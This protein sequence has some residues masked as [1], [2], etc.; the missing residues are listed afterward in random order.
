MILRDLDLQAR[1]ESHFFD[2]I[3]IIKPD[4]SV[5]VIERYTSN[6]EWIIVHT[7]YIQAE[8]G[9]M[10]PPPSKVAWESRRVTDEFEAQ[11]VLDYFLQKETT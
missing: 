1:E 5:I 2:F 8:P 10:L 3:T 9:H 4:D 6:G 7:P 11:A